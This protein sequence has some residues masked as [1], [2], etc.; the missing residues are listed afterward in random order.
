MG[1]RGAIK[2]VW[3]GIAPA[4]GHLKPGTQVKFL[5]FFMYDVS[6]AAIIFNLKDGTLSSF[7]P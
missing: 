3:C 4:S 6:L 2:G 5:T 7:S 1:F